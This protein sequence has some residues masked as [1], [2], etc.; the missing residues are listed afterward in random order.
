LKNAES[1]LSDVEN[2]EELIDATRLN[3]LYQFEVDYFD[4]MMGGILGKYGKPEE[5]SEEAKRN[6]PYS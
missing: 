5:G 3:M 4:T 2:S 1:L 6:L